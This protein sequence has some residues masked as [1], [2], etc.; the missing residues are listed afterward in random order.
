MRPALETPNSILNPADFDWHLHS[1][2]FATSNH[3]LNGITTQMIE[4]ERKPSILE[5][6]FTKSDRNNNLEDI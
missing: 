5:R 3:W 6:K 4:I 1:L 2:L